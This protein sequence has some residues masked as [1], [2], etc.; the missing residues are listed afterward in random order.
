MG[1]L[2]WVR[3]LF[4]REAR[5]IAILLFSVMNAFD[6]EIFSDSNLLIYKLF[7]NSF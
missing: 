3:Y 1:A 6:I 7:N 2:L 4:D 5:R